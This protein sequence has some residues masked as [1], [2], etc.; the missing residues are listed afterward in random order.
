MIEE[1]IKSITSKIYDSNKNQ[2]F[3]DK[4]FSKSLS[5]ISSYTEIK[6]EIYSILDLNDI[7]HFPNYYEEISK[8]QLTYEKD[9]GYI[10]RQ[11]Y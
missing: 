7:Y 3:K 6:W 9:T 10:Q 2:I 4:E 11:G 8:K 1:K 5:E